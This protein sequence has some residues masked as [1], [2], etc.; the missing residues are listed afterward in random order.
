MRD[1]TEF[2]DKTLKR[3]LESI[4]G[5]GQARVIGGRPRQ[6]NVIADTAKL[7]SLGLTVA[8]VVRALQSQNV[9]IPGG[10]VEQGLRDLTLRTYGR[11]DSPAEFGD[12]PI[13][14]A[15]RLSGEDQAMSRASRTASADAE[16]HRQRRRQAGGG[17]P[18]PQ[19]VGHQHRRGHRPRQG[20][21]RA[22]PRRSSPQGWEMEIVRDQS[23]YI[24]AA[25]DAVQG[26]SGARL[27]VRGADRP[28]FPQAASA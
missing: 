16:T 13:V 28:S 23:D 19:A 21:A 27:A 5:V 8:D 2:A 18:D 20:A 17:A 22:A 15:Q 4:S 14:A 6:I 12:I 9:Q 7:A 25:V 1:I 24:T 11:V 3:Q 10:Q 26:A